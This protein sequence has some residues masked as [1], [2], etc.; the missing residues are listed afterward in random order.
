MHAGR[1]NVAPTA[2]AVFCSS[3]FQPRTKST[4]SMRSLVLVFACSPRGNGYVCSF[5][6]NYCSAEMIR[7]QGG[8]GNATSMIGLCQEAKSSPDALRRSAGV[9]SCRFFSACVG[10]SAVVPI[11]DR[12][13]LP[14]AGAAFLAA[15]KIEFVFSCQSRNI[16]TEA[17]RACAPSPSRVNGKTWQATRRRNPPCFTATLYAAMLL[18]ISST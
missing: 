14:F 13:R 1:E 7:G 8:C 17:S 6:A 15:Q 5:S 12:T 9:N 10:L 18:L 11:S 4:M 16:S 3:S 2:A